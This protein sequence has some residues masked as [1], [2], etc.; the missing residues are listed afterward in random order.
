MLRQYRDSLTSRKL[1]P[2]T[3]KDRVTRY[4]S[5]VAFHLYQMYLNF[6]D[7]VKA[8]KSDPNNIKPPTQDDMSGEINRV[9]ATRIKVMEVSR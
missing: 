4:T 1:D 9:A 3:I 6:R 2:A 7:V 5:H 8:S